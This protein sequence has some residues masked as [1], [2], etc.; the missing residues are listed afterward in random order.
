MKTKAKI[1]IIAASLGLL[2]TQAFTA[3]SGINQ[4]D[5]FRFD[6]TN[7][8]GQD[9]IVENNYYYGDG[10]YI[11]DYYYASRIRRFHKPYVSYSY[12]NSYY[13][14]CYWYTYEP[15]YWGMSIYLGS[16]WNPVGLSISFGFP[17]RSYYRSYYYNPYPWYPVYNIVYRPRIV[18]R[19]Y[20]N[21]WYGNRIRY[22][23]PY[24]AN[25]YNYYNNYRDYYRDGYY[26]HSFKYASNYRAGNNYRKNQVVPSRTSVNRDNSRNSN[27]INSSRRSSPTNTAG[28]GNYNRSAEKER[29]V[30]TNTRRNTTIPNNNRDI[31][32]AQNR[33]ETRRSTY[34]PST[35][36][37]S[38]P[39]Y[40][41]HQKNSNRTRISKPAN[42][43]RSSSYRTSTKTRKSNVRSGNP[44][45]KNS[46]KRV[47]RSSGN[48]KS[49]QEKSSGRR[50]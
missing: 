26:S 6:R 21:T 38:R 40:K 18:N 16:M 13:T 12:Y 41:A 22:H 4:G 48:S 36:R 34:V 42:N 29:R 45:S 11:Y 8:A 5:H 19:Y 25:R 43:N 3:S 23:R 1:F 35:N 32:R 10:D 15:S 39:V 50:R 9:V 7:P 44:R 47:T 2:N 46:S 33:T 27:V 31:N 20:Y 14:D 49:D 28:T 30:V 24:Y 37:S 17:F